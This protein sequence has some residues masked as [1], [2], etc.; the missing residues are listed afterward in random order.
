MFY[1]V[2]FIELVVQ[3]A[4][5]CYNGGMTITWANEKRKLSQLQP[6]PRNP[7]QI[8]KDQAKRLVESFNEFGQVETIA[9]GPDNSVYNGHQRLNVL[10]DQH[11]PDYE[12]EVRVASRPL[13]EKEREKL[14]VF[15]HK[16]AAGSWNFDTLANEFEFGDL[17]DWGF[18]DKELTGFDESGLDLSKLPNPGSEEESDNIVTCPKC[19]FKYAV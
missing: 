7:R 10:M 19:G 1:A 18:S 12:V 17:I 6:W 14:T 5:T 2:L 13:T 3:L 11:G 4:K 15:L 8:T 9:V 16:G